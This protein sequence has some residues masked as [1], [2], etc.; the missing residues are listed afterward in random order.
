[1]RKASRES[2]S[3]TLSFRIACFGFIRILIHSLLSTLQQSSSARLLN[4]LFW[5]ERADNPRQYTS[6]DNLFL[7]KPLIVVVDSITS[8]T[9][10]ASN[11]RV[12]RFAERLDRAQAL[13]R[14]ETSKER[15]TTTHTHT[16]THTLHIITNADPNEAC[17]KL[18]S[19]GQFYPIA[20]SP[21]L[22]SPLSSLLHPA[23]LCTAARKPIPRA[24]Q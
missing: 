20:S 23:R 22:S 9:R 10:F 15:E 6:I 4:V 3:T 21:L 18:L 8:S 2:R 11:W 13:T 12:D 7:L 16:H 24:G 19:Q 1:M 5:L 17:H 14:D